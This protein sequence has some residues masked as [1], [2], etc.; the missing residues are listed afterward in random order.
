MPSYYESL[1]A[2]GKGE[3]PRELWEANG[4]PARVQSLKGNPEDRGQH[5]MRVYIYIYLYLFIY[6]FIYIYLFILIYLYIHIHACM[7]ECVHAYIHIHICYT[8]YTHILYRVE[9][10]GRSLNNYNRFRDVFVYTYI[11]ICVYIYIYTRVVY[12]EL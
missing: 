3:V 12:W 1:H 7:H 9:C 2:L 8:L 4:S 5:Y 10:R 11:V 6:L